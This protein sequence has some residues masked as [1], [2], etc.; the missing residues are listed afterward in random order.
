MEQAVTLPDLFTFY[1]NFE[2]RVTCDF[3]VNHVVYNY[4][5]I[6]K[7]TEI[8]RGINSGTVLCNRDA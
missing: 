7:I 3:F 8:E 6:Y 4:V 5:K 2:T 1:I